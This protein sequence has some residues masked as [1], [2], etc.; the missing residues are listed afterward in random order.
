[1][2]TLVKSVLRGSLT[3]PNSDIDMS[4]ST[5]MDASYD[6]KRYVRKPAYVSCQTFVEAEAEPS[7]PRGA[8]WAR[9]TTSPT[10][11]T[12]SGE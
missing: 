2:K 7:Q 5:M 6:R 11:T 3:T 10:V 4:A 8:R 1:M 12:P 9:D